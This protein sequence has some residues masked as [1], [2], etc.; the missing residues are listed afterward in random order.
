MQMCIHADKQVCKGKHMSRY[1]CEQVCKH[2][3]TGMQ[4]FKYAFMQACRYTGCRYMAI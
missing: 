4:V 3:G 2:T 1:T